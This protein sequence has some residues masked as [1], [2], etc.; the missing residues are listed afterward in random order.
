[1]RSCGMSFTAW[2][3]SLSTML[4]GYIHAVLKDRSS[5][6]SFCCIVFPCVTVTHFLIHSFTDGHLG[7]FQ[8]FAIVNCAAE[9]IGVHRYFS[10]SVSGFLE[11]NPSSGIA[12]SKCNSIF[13]FFRKLH[14]VFHTG[15]TSLHSQQKCTRVPFSPP[16]R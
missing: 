9:N 10:I 11:Y 4:S 14:T 7:C 12:G 6:F 16:P 5:F 15:C 13:S 1:M 8:H 3:I 2:L